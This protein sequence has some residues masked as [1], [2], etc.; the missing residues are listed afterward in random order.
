MSAPYTGK[1]QVFM[2][3]RPPATME[4]R[5]SWQTNR[6]DGGPTTDDGE[7]AVVRRPPSVVSPSASQHYEN[8]V[9]TEL[10]PDLISARRWAHIYLWAPRLCYSLPRRWTPMWDAVC[11]I[12]RGERGYSDIR[13]RLGAFGFLENLLPAAI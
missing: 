10:M 8:L 5:M 4:V 11:K 6:D 2:N 13:K 1:S 7:S 9:D 12:V 3:A